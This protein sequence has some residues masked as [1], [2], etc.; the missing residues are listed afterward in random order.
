MMMFYADFTLGCL[1]KYL[2]YN[3]IVDY[4]C[5]GIVLCIYLI[6]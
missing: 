1:C 2:Y 4:Y 5:A 6:Y 3:V